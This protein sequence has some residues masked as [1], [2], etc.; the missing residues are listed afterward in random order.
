MKKT[1]LLILAASAA[2]VA[3]SCG[4]E[5]GTEQKE[6]PNPT[7]LSVSLFKAGIAVDPDGFNM[8]TD[9]GF[10]RFIGD[11]NWKSK[12]LFYLPEWDSEAETAYAGQRTIHA[13][14]NVDGW[15]D[16]AVQSI[17]VKKNASYTFTLSYRGAWN[18]LNAYMGF[19]GTEGHDQNLKQEGVGTEWQEYSYTLANVDDTKVDA[20]FGG[21]CWYN[22]WLELDC[23]KVIPTGT[24]ND[25]FIPENV[26]NVA[27]TATNAS[28]NEI[29]SF[30]KV[31]AWNEADGTVSAVLSDAVD[32]EGNTITGVYAQT[33][34]SAANGLKFITVNTDPVFESA[35]VPTGGVTAGDIK[36]VRY[37]VPVAAADEESTW[38]ASEAG[39]AVCTDGKTWTKAD[40]RWNVDG[41]FVK[42]S[43][44]LKDNYVYMFG[45]PAG[46]G[47]VMAYVAR[48][49]SAKVADAA[50][51]EYWDGAEWVKGDETAAA[52]IF[53]GPVDDMSVVYNPSRYTYMAIYRSATTGG[54]VYRDAGLPE[55]EWS[56]EKILL[57][58]GENAFNAPSIISVSG[59]ELIFITNDVE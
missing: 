56:G 44:L 1:S 32:A 50:E 36:A 55:G 53:Y 9:G 47:N 20:F 8:L 7:Q 40:A 15:R 57:L 18:A 45:S 22:L 30:G 54:L 29:K 28:Y 43:Y 52:G 42:A 12:S 38:T 34:G 35:C 31:I 23:L 10:E 16:V 27:S 39:L 6:N 13:D 48:V 11:E 51:Y 59:D 41:N 14:C 58:D 37:Y 2:L 26:E 25:T 17:C 46:D 19:R 4:K 21:W 5:N 3:V 24:N 49:A 33:T